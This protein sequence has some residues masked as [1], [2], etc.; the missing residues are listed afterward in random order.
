MVIIDNG[1]TITSVPTG[2]ILNQVGN[3]A[4][5]PFAGFNNIFVDVMD[6]NDTVIAGMSPLRITAYGKDG[7]DTMYGSVYNDTLSGADG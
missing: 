6:R 3:S 2:W 7:N 5:G 1:E 4:T